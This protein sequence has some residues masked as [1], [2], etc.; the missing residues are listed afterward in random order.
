MEVLL[1]PVVMADPVPCPWLVEE[2]LLMLC[3][4]NGSPFTPQVPPG[5]AVRCREDPCLTTAICQLE[6]QS[7]LLLQNTIPEPEKVTT[8]A[9]C[10]A[11]SV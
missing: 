7:I 9:L 4:S 10:F 11:P 5:L 6:V 2:V 1:A 3:R 8:R